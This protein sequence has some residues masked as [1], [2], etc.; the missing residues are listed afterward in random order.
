MTLLKSSYQD[1]QQ[2]CRSTGRKKRAWQ[3]NII[4]LKPGATAASSGYSFSPVVG[5][6]NSTVLLRTASNLNI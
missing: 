1:I 4:L 3:K 2:I 5:F 6:K